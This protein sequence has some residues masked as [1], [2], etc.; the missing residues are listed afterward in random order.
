MSLKRLY[1]ELKDMVTTQTN[2]I[3]TLI[4]NNQSYTINS[5]FRTWIDSQINN[6]L[7]EK[8]MNKRYEQLVQINQLLNIMNSGLDYSDTSTNNLSNDVDIFKN[9]IYLVLQSIMKM[10]GT[11]F[12]KK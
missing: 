1:S 4:A 10:F 9:R 12:T 5:Q 6:A 11:F 7:G 3:N 8:N 2:Q